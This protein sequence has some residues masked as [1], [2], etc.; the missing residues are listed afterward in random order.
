VEPWDDSSPVEALG[1]LA[2]RTWLPGRTLRIVVLTLAEGTY[3]VVA[4]RR[5]IG[6]RGPETE[7]S[8]TGV[9]VVSLVSTSRCDAT[10]AACRHSD[11]ACREHWPE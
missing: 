11:R 4:P 8:P 3:A 7:R 6:K 5:P 2:T 10:R 1:S 9:A